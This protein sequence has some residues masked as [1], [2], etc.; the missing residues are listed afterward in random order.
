MP[1]SN[2]IPTPTHPPACASFRQF[3][4]II[5]PLAR[6]YRVVAF[7]AFGCGQSPKPEGAWAAYST[8]ALLG[9]FLEIYERYKVRAYVR[10][11][12]CAMDG[13]KEGIDCPSDT[14]PLPTTPYHYQASD[15]V[16][17]PHPHAHAP[18]NPTN[19]TKPK[20]KPNTTRAGAI[21]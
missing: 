8:E 3:A 9:D 13:W 5:P 16:N 7:D 15:V 21:C 19:Q 12:M 1:H 4:R 20:T 6:Q 2:S 18:P 17:R 10:M 14:I 11:H